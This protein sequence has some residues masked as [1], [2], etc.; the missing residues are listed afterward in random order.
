M[1][2]SEKLKYCRTKA[3][4]TQGEV[5]DLI[6]VSRKTI[7]GWEN[8]RSFPD[9]NGL[10]ALSDLYHVS[11]DDLVRDDRLLEHYANEAKHTKRE[12]R[13]LT[14]AYYI[15]IIM[16]LVSYLNLFHP[17]GF[18]TILIPFIMVINEVVFM[19]YFNDWQRFA[20]RRWLGWLAIIVFA[21]VFALHVYLNLLTPT[22]ITWHHLH[23]YSFLN[24][25]FL[26][27]YILIALISI[28]IEIM[29]F[30]KPSG[31]THDD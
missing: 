8:D 16:W 20:G 28:G 10:V 19:T 21:A 12:Q 13:V 15:N 18:H 11:V 5:S 4:L 25:L 24:G 27:R 14:Y 6:H 22:I 30:F 9:I 17:H 23:N 2:L 1:K 26:G 31:T 3:N 7:S 29:V